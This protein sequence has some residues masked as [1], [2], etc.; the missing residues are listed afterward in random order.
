MKQTA[1]EW[2]EENL[3]M[4]LP[5]SQFNDVIIQNIIEQAKE[6]EKQQIIDTW[7]DCKR[8]YTVR[9]DC[10]PPQYI[11]NEANQYYEKQFKKK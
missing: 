4:I 9:M 3:K 1:I 7:T 2:L 11:V 10:Y 6:I 8:E 5:Q